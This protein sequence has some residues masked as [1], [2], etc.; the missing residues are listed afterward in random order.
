MQPK[1]YSQI[2]AVGVIVGQAMTKGGH[3]PKKGAYSLTP[4]THIQG[5]ELPWL[6][7]PSKK[8]VTLVHEVEHACPLIRHK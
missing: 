6:Y 3:G 1:F 2:A 5:S 8:S 4:H 7:N